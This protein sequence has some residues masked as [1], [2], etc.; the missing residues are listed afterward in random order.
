MLWSVSSNNAQLGL[1]PEEDLHRLAQ[2][3]KKTADHDN[4]DHDNDDHDGEEHDNEDDD[5]E[6][7]DEEHKEDKGVMIMM[8]C[9]RVLGSTTVSSR[10][11]EES[12]HLNPPLFY[13]I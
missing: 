2:K 1:I 10:N 11:P 4:E 12:L 5:N 6:D 8:T 13:L 9:D 7:D 3:K